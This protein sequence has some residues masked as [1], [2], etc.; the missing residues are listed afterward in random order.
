MKNSE[1]VKTNHTEMYFKN[2]RSKI[3]SS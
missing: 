1:T 3:Y 2:S